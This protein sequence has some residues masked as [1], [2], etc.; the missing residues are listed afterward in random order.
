MELP[1][2]RYV[3]DYYSDERDA[4]KILAKKKDA[5]TTFEYFSADGQTYSVMLT[6]RTRCNHSGGETRNL[7]RYQYRVDKD[8]SQS[9]RVDDS[10]D[11]PG[12]WQALTELSSVAAQLELIEGLNRDIRSAIRLSLA[13]WFRVNSKTS[14]ASVKTLWSG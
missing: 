9:N 4:S 10:E 5:R 3:Q 13:R 12:C 6:L 14:G 11:L 8:L 7:V 2:C 1:V